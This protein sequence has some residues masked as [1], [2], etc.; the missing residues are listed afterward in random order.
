[1]SSS[2]SVSSSQAQSA[3]YYQET[4]P[5][6]VEKSASLATTG[7]N[8]FTGPQI[9]TDVD[10]PGTFVSM[11]YNQ[12]EVDE[13]GKYSRLNSGGILT[14]KILPESNTTASIQ[15]GHSDI[16]AEITDLNEAVVARTIIS[17]SQS[18]HDPD[19]LIE[20]NIKFKPQK[21]FPDCKYKY[22]LRFDF[23][24]PEYNSCVEFNGLQHYEPIDFFGGDDGFK[25]S[26][27]RDKIKKEYC[28]NNNI[29]LIIIRYDEDDIINSLNNHLKSYIPYHP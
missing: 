11:S 1:V 3:S 8:T 26:Q 23:Y 28:D 9:I 4:D 6:F 7:S 2:Y 18:I 14:K 10:N 27:I 20:N 19:N 12:I 13:G 25:L 15:Y 17:F 16:V 29:P 24:L 21:S 22:P 5:I